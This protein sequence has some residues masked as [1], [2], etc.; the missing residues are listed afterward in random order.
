MMSTGTYVRKLTGQLAGLSASDTVQVEVIPLQPLSRLLPVYTTRYQI[1]SSLWSD[2]VKEQVVHWVPHCINKLFGWR[3]LQVALPSGPAF[4]SRR[5]ENVP[6][7]S[8]SAAC[9]ESGGGNARALYHR[10][11]AESDVESPS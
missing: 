10:Q 4:P 6:D 2:R 3:S 5:S 1:N 9:A 8:R 7:S 11:R